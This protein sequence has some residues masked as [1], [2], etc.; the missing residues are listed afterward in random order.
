MYSRTP[1][2]IDTVVIYDD[3]RMPATARTSTAA[4]R[5]RRD[6][7]QGQGCL[8][9][10]KGSVCEVKFR[11]LILDEDATVPPPTCGARHGQVPNS[12]EHRHSRGRC[13]EDG[14]EAGVHPQPDLPPGQGSAAAYAGLHRFALH[15]LPYETRRT[16]IYSAGPVRADD[17]AQATEDAA[18]ATLKAIQ[19]ME[20]AELGRAAHPRSAT[21]LPIVQLDG[22]T[23]ASAAR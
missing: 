12:G 8:V 9:E 10:A 17:M 21:L 14:S 18:G 16:G 2:R 1:T 22:C 11:D 7:H 19:A 15:L 5:K 4:R 13:G 23:S 20:N 6:L 3:L